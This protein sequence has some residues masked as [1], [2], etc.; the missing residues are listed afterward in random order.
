SGGGRFLG[1]TVAEVIG[2]DDT[3]LFSPE[4]ARAIMEG[5]RRIMAT[6]E[7]QTYEDVGTAAGVT[8]TYLSTKGPYRD[9]QGTILGV[10][11]IS[12]DIS[13][14]K[15]AEERFRLVVESAPSGMLMI[16]REG[17]IVLVNAQTETMFGYGRGE[18]L[19]Q[20]VELLVPDRFRDEHPA[21]RAG[22]FANPTVR[23]MGTGRELSGR[24]RDGSEFPM[25]LGLTPIDMAEGLFVLSAI[26]DITERKR[27]EETRARLAA[28]VELSDD[29]IL[30]KDLDGTIL[31][32]NRGAEKMFGY[33]AAE[34]VGRSILLL[35]PPERPGEVPAILARLRRGERLENYETVRLRKDGSRI[36]VSLNISPM[37]DATGRVTGASVIGRDLTTRKGS[38]RR[39]E[40]VH[41]VASALASS[42]SLL[43]AAEPVLRTVGKTL[44]CDLGVLWEVDA[45]ADVLRCAGVWH[46]PG[47]EGTA[48][49]RFNRQITFA[50]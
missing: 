13:E 10:I 47:I 46:P 15:R 36:E 27:A 38:G 4:T 49:E 23:A 18:L 22:F 25:E 48:F 30:S 28:I 14:R 50:R 39:L 17:R 19:G 2:K 41:A 11:G 6:G 31:T 42:A 12:R 16:N 45:A 34:V 1:R 21:Y 20:P 3:E 24:R 35:V 44:R 7:T 33:A 26:A 8:R 29:A 9:A 43:E 5:D 40:A 32:W 37:P